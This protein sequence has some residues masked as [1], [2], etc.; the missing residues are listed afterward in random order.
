MASLC[1]KFWVNRFSFPW[2]ELIA[3]GLLP[4][5][6]LRHAD[7]TL[8]SCMKE[9]QTNKPETRPIGQAWLC[10]MSVSAVKLFLC[11]NC[12]KSMEASPP[13]SLWRCTGRVP[14]Q[15][16]NGTHTS[17]WVIRPHGASLLPYRPLSVLWNITAHQNIKD[18][19]CVCLM[20]NE[21]QQCHP[22]HSPDLS[23]KACWDIVK[24]DS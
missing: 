20:C 21:K 4:S 19:K 5:P 18:G 24:G 9:C 10:P 2:W 23:L 22:P 12:I 6:S 16:Q 11:C 7:Q 15:P 13:S 8:C 3:F 1:L 14:D 17:I